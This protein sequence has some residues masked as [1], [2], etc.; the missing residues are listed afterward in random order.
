MSE[1]LHIT[2]ELKDLP[3]DS[4]SPMAFYCLPDRLTS[5]Q[6]MGLNHGR[7]M[8]WYEKWAVRVLES[9]TWPLRIVALHRK[10]LESVG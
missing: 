10:N 7:E 9:R 2:L 6:V 3:S 8:K 4:D 1:V 5:F